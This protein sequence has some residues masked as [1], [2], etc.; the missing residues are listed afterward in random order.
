MAQSYCRSWPVIMA[1]IVG[2][3]PLSY[4]LLR[5]RYFSRL[6]VFWFLVA[7]IIRFNP[8]TCQPEVCAGLSDGMD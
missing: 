2:V 6:L 5:F 8:K 4:I 3:G 1:F 7:G